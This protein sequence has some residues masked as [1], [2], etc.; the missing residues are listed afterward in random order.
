MLL[1]NDHNFSGQ[2]LRGCSLVLLFLS[3]LS[4]FVSAFAGA[5]TGAELISQNP[6]DVF[7]G[8]VILITLAVFCLTTIC[9]G[10]VTA[11]GA[12]AVAGLA[13]TVSWRPLAGDQKYAL[14]RM[15]GAN[16]TNA[17]FIGADL[18]EAN[19]QDANLSGARLKLTQLDGTDL[20]GACL[21]GAYIENW[22]IT[23]QTTLDNKQWR[24]ISR[25]L[26][27]NKPPST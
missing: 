9:R 17:S 24:Y 16:L 23:S 26:S 15:R 11:L 14:I 5:L 4:G 7:A 22:G 6:A 21:T 3:T 12:V 19:L 8:V 20:T 13:A 25:R 27:R 2:N 18:C 10:L 1:N